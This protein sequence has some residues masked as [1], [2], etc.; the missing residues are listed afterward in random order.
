MRISN[1]RKR[2]KRKEQREME[3]YRLTLGPVW[4]TS[5]TVNLA[6][7]PEWVFSSR[8]IVAMGGR[9]RQARL[10]LQEMYREI[11]MI[12]GCCFC[13]HV[14]TKALVSARAARPGEGL[15]PLGLTVPPPLLRPGPQA[16][17]YGVCW[18]CRSWCCHG[19]VADTWQ[20]VRKL[21]APQ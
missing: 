8:P 15:A 13:I 10:A 20:R 2:R 7:I 18:D 12:H 17:A 16:F 21:E 3:K 19:V 4:L 1:M 9:V 6:Q 14:R 5:I 11:C